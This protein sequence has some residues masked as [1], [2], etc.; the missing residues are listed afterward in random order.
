MSY[1]FTHTTRGYE[2]NSDSDS[3]YYNLSDSSDSNRNVSDD[4]SSI[5]DPYESEQSIDSDS[6]DASSTSDNVK[7]SKK[8]KEQES[9]LFDQLCEKYNFDF[10]G[11]I[12]SSYGCDHY[13]SRCKIVCPECPEGKDVYPCHKC[14]NAKMMQLD[15]LNDK[16][17]TEHD[18]LSKDIDHVVCMN[19]SERQEFTGKCKA[20]NTSFARYVCLECKLTNNKGSKDSYYHCKGCGCCFVG[21]RSDFKHCNKCDVCIQKQQ[22]DNH[23]CRKA[24]S[25]N[26]RVCTICQD[27][28]RTQTPIIMICGHMIH[29]ECY[30]FL[31]KESYKCPVCS[32]TIKDASDI[33]RKIAQEVQATPLP[34]DLRKE[35][36]IK[37]NDCEKENT[38]SF[39]YIGSMCPNCDSFN[40]YEL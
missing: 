39:H 22:F 8:K 38:V 11:I 18:L 16:D 9:A 21:K 34:P 5:P 4:N 26:D 20:C 17:L 25:D 37:C 1:R 23:P 13:Q 35:I 19:C 40:T 14:H 33:F 24:N 36:K 28:I 6:S 30:N 27:G 15:P 32:R 29:E 3:D 31:I 7:R 2:N 12:A 10:K